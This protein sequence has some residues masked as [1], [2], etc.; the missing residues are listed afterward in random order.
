M[1]EKVLDISDKHHDFKWLIPLQTAAKNSEEGLVLLAHDDPMS[2]ILGLVNC[3]RREPGE[4]K[5]RCI[6]LQTEAPD[7]NSHVYRNQ[8]KK[9]FAINVYNNGSW[10]TYRHLLLNTD[11]ESKSNCSVHLQ[12][13]SDLCSLKWIENPPENIYNLNPDEDIVYVSIFFLMKN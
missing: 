7:F 1:P 3:M 13:K 5:T 10:G 2:G 9:S 4:E 6:F 12:R 8:L 11:I